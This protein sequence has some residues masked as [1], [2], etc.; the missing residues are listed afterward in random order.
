MLNV[1][2]DVFPDANKLP[3]TNLPVS[4]TGPVHRSVCLFPFL[5]DASL[6]LTLLLLSFGF[7]DTIKFLF[8]IYLLFLYFIVGNIENMNLL[9]RA[10]MEA[11]LKTFVRK[12]HNLL[13]EKID[14]RR[15]DIDQLTN[16]QTLILK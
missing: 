15:L 14:S 5:T 11:D 13:G 2:R 16:D 1:D 7:I 9:Y 4:A 10:K 12:K 6:S 8:F 3:D